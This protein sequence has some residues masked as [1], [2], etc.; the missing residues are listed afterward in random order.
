MVKAIF[1]DVG[2]VLVEDTSGLVQKR[3]ARLL[4]IKGRSLAR[5]FFGHDWTEL[6]EGR[7]SEVAFCLRVCQK[8]RRHCPPRRVLAAIF[9]RQ[10]RKVNRAL[11]IAKLLRA[12]GYI[13]G[14]ISNTSHSHTTQSAALIN[15]YAAFW[16]V[17]LSSRV[18]I[19]KPKKKIFQIARQRARVRFSEMA[20]FDDHQSNVDAAR[21]L[22]IKA[23]VYKNPAQLVRQLRRYGVKI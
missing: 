14:V 22:G 6:L 7:I 10:V 23:F 12:R 19:K 2:G 5:V 17:V 20:Y 3:F 15:L 13:T 1:F 9:Q 4:G 8:L 18:H 21:K 11:D 16:P